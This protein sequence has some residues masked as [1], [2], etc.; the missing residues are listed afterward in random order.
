MILELFV[1]FICYIS[2]ANRLLLQGT[3]G[4]SLMIISLLSIE[5]FVVLAYPFR[6]QYLTRFRLKVVISVLC[7][8]IWVFSLLEVFLKLGYTVP[9]VI[10]TVLIVSVVLVIVIWL[11]IHR[12]I[13]QHKRQ[14][15]RL[16]SPTG[17]MTNFKIVMKNTK[18]SYLVSGSTFLCFF[19]SVATNVYYLLAFLG[20]QNVAIPFY[21]LP[22]FFT[23]L[24]ASSL[25]NPVILL[26]RKRDFRNAIKNL[27]WHQ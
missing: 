17:A 5:R 26:Y 6:S 24:F 11:W 27:L 8:V 3:C 4:M 23:L 12:L 21:I 18:T 25:L 22:W 1:P 9:I 19:P 20:R 14:I 15:A 10:G 16:Q 2:V 13:L 7:A